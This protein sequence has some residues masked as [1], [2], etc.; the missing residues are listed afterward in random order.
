M[1]AQK[2]CLYS[3][4]THNFNYSYSEKCAYKYIYAYGRVKLRLELP[5]PRWFQLS[6]AD[7]LRAFLGPG[8]SGTPQGKCI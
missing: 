1:M 8:P 7:T 4:N 6:P 2:N 5:W 3:P